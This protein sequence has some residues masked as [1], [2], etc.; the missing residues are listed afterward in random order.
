MKTRL[1]H[2]HPLACALLGLS[3]G[4]GLMTP[5]H[6]GLF[7]DDE[8]RRQIT[9]IRNQLNDKVDIQSRAQ[10]ELSN[11]LE[12]LRSENAKLRGQVEVLTIEL[13]S[14][15]RRQKDFYLDLDNRLRKLETAPREA[16]ATAAT[17]DA[18]TPPAK[19][20][21]PAQEAR[22][23]DGALNLMKAS[24]Y[25]DA[26]AAFDGFLKAYPQSDMAPSAQYWMG[27]AYSVLDCRKA[28]EVHG[29]L[30]AKWP[31]HAR[32][33]DA[34]LAISNCQADLGNNAGARKTLENLIAKYPQSSAAD[35]ARK[36][37]KK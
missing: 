15:Q 27:N 26:A 13:D 10:M 23:Y 7:D 9:D 32:A 8:A 37:L 31:D 36:S 12:N 1:A 18:A 14:A 29:A 21:D 25:K 11:Q 5:A 19:T 22:D 17:P 16:A 2:H 30:V 35:K 28:I 3:L 34:L 33:P 6:A 20:V 4:A 24:K